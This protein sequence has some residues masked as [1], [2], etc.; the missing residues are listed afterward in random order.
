MKERVLTGLLLAAVV[1]VYA[2]TLANQFAMD[3]E[4]YILRNAQVTDPSLHRLF[5][6]NPVST[7]F[8]P[9]TFATL[10]LNWALGAA[11]PVGYHLLNLVL[12]AGA[13]WLLFILL[14]ELLGQTSNGTTVAF[15][16]ALLYA[17]H[18]IHTEAVAWAVGRAEL[19]AAGFLFAGWILH[20]RDR[21]AGS[22][23]CFALAVLSKE[24]AVAFFPLVLLGD[25][26]I[27][28]WKSRIRYAIAAVLTIFFLGLLW[29]VQGGR[30]G[31]ADI[32]AADNPLA[33]LSAGWRIL[34]ALRVAWKYVA[35]QIYPATLS[36]DYSFNQISI[37]QDWRHTLPAALAVAAVFGAWIWALRK[38]R[39]GWA[40]AG[41]VY[42]AGFA[43]TANILVPTGTI[44]GERL[45]Y[46]PSAGFCLLLALSWDWIRQKKEHLAWGIL[47]AIILAFSVRTVIRNRDWRDT[48]ALYSAAVRAVPNDA[49]M[50]AN[51][52]GE[53]FSRK[54]L[55]LAAKEYQITL[56]INP[57]SA[58]ALG[59][60]AAL[61][62]QRG[63]YQ[64]AGEMMEKAL[65]MSGRNN[66][67][68]DFMVVTFATI[69]M[70]TNHSDG[71]LEYLNREIAEAPAYAPAWSTRA[72][73][74][75]QHGE[76]AEARADADA[77]LRLDPSNVE[78]QDVLSRI[79]ALTQTQSPH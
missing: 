9:V 49:K 46:L 29:T 10:A 62:T 52:A 13:T 74:H 14:Q 33:H 47:V 36:C 41:G 58:D 22:L 23:A 63:N 35:L 26:A 16:A 17:V 68:Y 70:K 21:P 69:L 11:N 37:F 54:Q 57:E 25:Y 71:A 76:Y 48:F 78:A 60:Y 79:D 38:R 39:A 61:E 65:H 5:S 72:E 56:R 19:L 32:P 28:K 12:H 51:L 4:L 6:P 2:N 8:R 24:S 73:L 34:N 31:P 1:L 30:F 18:P 43:V 42:F 27:G 59:S 7:V 44:M 67:N 45:A 75:C 3:D 55:D 20:L 66:L 50:H 77:A 40:L 53:Y 64:A 15:A